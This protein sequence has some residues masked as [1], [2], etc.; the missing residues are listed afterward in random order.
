MALNLPTIPLYQKPTYFVYKSKLQGMRD[1]PT[2]AGPV[3]NVEDWKIGG[4]TEAM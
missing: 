4:D 1:N 2:S 3:W